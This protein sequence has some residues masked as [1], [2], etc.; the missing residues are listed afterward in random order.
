ME[1]REWQ[2]HLPYVKQKLPNA[3]VNLVNLVHM[4]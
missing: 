2:L 4:Y 3:R 1:I